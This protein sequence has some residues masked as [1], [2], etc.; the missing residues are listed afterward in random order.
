MAFLA[1]YVFP[2]EIHARMEKKSMATVLSKI[3]SAGVDKCKDITK[4]SITFLV[5]AVR[6]EFE[7]EFLKYLRLVRRA[8]S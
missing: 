8:A 6:M 4:R 3:S 2:L 7:P 5:G 1:S